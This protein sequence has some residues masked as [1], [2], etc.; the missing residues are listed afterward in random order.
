MIY[1][2][3]LKNTLPDSGC[4]VD[5]DESANELKKFTCQLLNANGQVTTGYIYASDESEAKTMLNEARYRFANLV[6]S[7]LARVHPEQKKGIF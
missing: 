6:E 4:R 3:L 5:Y 1:N 2:D 7:K